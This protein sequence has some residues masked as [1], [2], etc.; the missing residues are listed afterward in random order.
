MA[1]QPPSGLTLADTL[2]HEIGADG[3]M[4]LS[5]FVAMALARYYA[6]RDPLGAKGDFITAPEISQIFGEMIGLWLAVMWQVMGSP[7]RVVLAEL[8]PGRGTLMAD[9]LRAAGTVPAFLQAAEIWLVETS[10]LLRQAQQQK[11]A[12]FAVRWV[13]RIEDLP[14]ASILVIANEFFDALPIEQF[15]RVQNHWRRQMVGLGPKGDFVFM[16]GEAV[17]LPQQDAEGSIRESCP[18]GQRIIARLGRQVAKWGGALLIIDYG[19]DSNRAGDT[20]QA[21][22][23]HQFHPV[24]VDPGEADLTAHV[25]FYALAEAAIPA[26]AYGPVGQGAFLRALGIETRLQGLSARVSPEIA[27]DLTAGVL[28]LIDPSAMGNLFRVM[29][30]THPAYG[31]PPGFE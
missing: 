21:V 26:R 23:N 16:P 8:G 5:R 31:P 17:T 6:G 29:A 4:P 20:L 3:P 24:L 11:L 30:L 12:G 27:D 2:R 7:H 14:D 1:A 19:Y 9:V 22:K 28:R 15:I 25:D 10:P 13:E 18:E